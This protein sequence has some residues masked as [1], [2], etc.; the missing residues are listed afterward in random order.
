MGPLRIGLSTNFTDKSL[1]ALSS[2]N[3]TS[4]LTPGDGFRKGAGT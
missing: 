4:V 1:G 3:I 2:S